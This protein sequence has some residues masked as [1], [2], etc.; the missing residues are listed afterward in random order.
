MDQAGLISKLDCLHGFHVYMK[1][2][3]LI[4]FQKMSVARD[5]E[6][7]QSRDLAS[8]HNSILLKIVIILKIAVIFEVVVAK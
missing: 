4:N 3:E 5:F 1:S 6:K 7:K 8:S 2:F